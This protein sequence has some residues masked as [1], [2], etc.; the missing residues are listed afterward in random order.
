MGRMRV[1]PSIATGR[2]ITVQAGCMPQATPPAVSYRL[3]A[4][5]Q[6]IVFGLIAL[7]A[8]IGLA[9]VFHHTLAALVRVWDSQKEYSLG[10]V[11]PF[12]SLFL[13]YQRL[14]RLA[15]EPVV[16]SWAGTAIVLLGLGLEGFGRLSTMDTVAQY[17]F[18]L[19]VWGLVLAYLG[20]PGTRI[21]L[22]PL[23]SLMF[24][25]PMPNYLLR[26]IS[27]TLQLLS[28][29]LGV[30]LIRWCGTSVYLEGNV[31]DLGVM[32]LQVVEACSGLRYLISLS[33]LT[34]VVAYF[35]RDRLW[36]R[37]VVFLSAIPITIA[38][39]SARIALAGV[40]SDH[41]GPAMAEGLL[42]DFEGVT[43]FVAGVLILLAE[44]W[45][46]VKV[47]G[48]KRNARD[49]LAIGVPKLDLARVRHLVRV[50]GKPAC[51]AA[52]LIAIAAIVTVSAPERV[53]AYPQR[54]EFA[55][56][57]LEF[58]QWKG[59]PSRLEP[60]I[61]AVLNTDDYL[62]V[63][64]FGNEGGVNLHASYYASQTEGNSTH[65]PRACLPAGG[66]EILS[67]KTHALEKISFRS[68]PLK[69]NRVVIQKGDI[70]ALV[71]YWFQQRG[72]VITDEYVVK[73]Y[74]LADSFS[75]QRTDGAMVRLVT[76]VGSGEDLANADA[77][78]QSFAS[79]A[80]PEL[81][82]FIPE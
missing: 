57:P 40:T 14:D 36:K 70:T 31:I 25:V 13:V 63:D 43:I 73:L 45:I 56:F 6:S 2:V 15:A 49:A 66:W 38:L 72:R 55:S 28:S 68:G 69:V 51:A 12:L 48:G 44:V 41:W 29:Q 59:V 4:S 62:L 39:N 9:L 71:Y 58:A 82:R 60:E 47:G 26:D 11:V 37:I 77:R 42:H 61:A 78:L 20:W 22:M 7:A 64:Y 65:S 75:R 80:M 54:P 74:I 21:I 1:R 81:R 35:Y 19:V 53:H 76:V 52:A 32:K 8:L 67:F 50:P 18:L 33:I 17:G 34:F 27:Q 3:N 23:A 24:M 5:A 46:L 79:V 16:G 30:E 10:Y